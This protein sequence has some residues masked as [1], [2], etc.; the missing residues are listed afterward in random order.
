MEMPDANETRVAKARMQ[1]EKETMVTIACRFTRHCD[2]ST[3]YRFCVPPFHQCTP[4]FSA[5][6]L[7]MICG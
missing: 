6:P 1:L 5:V 4:Q 2:Q 7:E 3:L